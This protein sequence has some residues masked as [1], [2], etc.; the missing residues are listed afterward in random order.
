MQKHISG[1]AIFYTSELFER[2][3][4]HE[5]FALSYPQD[6]ENPVENAAEACGKTMK[7]YRLCHGFSTRHGGISTLPHLS[8][9]N[10]GFG[11]GEPRETTLTNYARFASLLGID[12]E[13]LLA[14]RQTHTDR[15]MTVG[16]DH[17][18]L[19]LTAAED[20]IPLAP[21]FRDGWDAFVT[22]APDV[23]LSVRIADCVPVLFWDPVHG[24]IGAAHAGWRGTYGEIVGKTVCGMERLGAD[25]KTVLACI[26]TSIGVCCYE[27]DDAFYERFLERF[28]EDICARVFTVW[29]NGRRHC[30]LRLLN[31]LI[32]EKNGVAP[33]HIE[34]SALCTCCDP[35]QF[36]SHR[37][38]MK[39]DGKRGLMAAVIAMESEKCPEKALKG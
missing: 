37:A 17:R 34:V 10:F 24:V 9:L 20:E 32:L 7:N 26:G 35:A 12:A 4:E 15:V 16:T 5:S 31:R 36:H 38:A 27:I 23:A 29:E 11:L 28:G 8:D 25:R 3:A 33:S 2:A 1:S 21:D 6:A 39:R 30:D 22:D 18:G 19:G 14:A 13:H